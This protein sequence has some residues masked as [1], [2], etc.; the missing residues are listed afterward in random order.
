MCIRD[1]THTHTQTDHNYEKEGWKETAGISVNS[2]EQMCL[3]TVEGKGCVGMSKGTTV[4]VDMG[5]DLWFVGRIVLRTGSKG[6][7]QMTCV[8]RRT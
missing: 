4:A 1:S 6:F 7:L 8:G 2:S 5:Q 3:E